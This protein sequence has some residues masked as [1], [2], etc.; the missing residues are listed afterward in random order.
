MALKYQALNGT[1]IS[2]TLTIPGV[3][4][5]GSGSPVNLNY[6]RFQSSDLAK[7]GFL[8]FV[9]PTA[10]NSSATE[11]SISTSTSL[12]TV[13]PERIATSTYEGVMYAG[14]NTNKLVFTPYVRYTS[15]TIVITGKLNVVYLTTNG[16]IVAETYTLTN[17]S[18]TS[19]TKGITITLPYVAGIILSITHEP[20]T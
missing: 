6:I 10:A 15:S 20:T 12:P 7:E 3:D 16:S 19:S 18:F 11:L 14:L 17:T 5:L 9:G 13:T 4:V 2:N 8:V 1:V